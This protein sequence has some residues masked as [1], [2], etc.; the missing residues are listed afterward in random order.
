MGKM[1]LNVSF[2]VGFVDL[3]GGYFQVKSFFYPKYCLSTSSGALTVLFTCNSADPNQRFRVTTE[4]AVNALTSDQIVNTM[5]SQKQMAENGQTNGTDYQALKNILLASLSMVDVFD[6]SFVILPNGTTYKP[7][8]QEWANAV[9]GAG[10]LD[11]NLKVYTKSAKLIGTVDRVLGVTQLVIAVGEDQQ[12]FNAD[13]EAGRIPGNNTLAYIT[14][15]AAQTATT[16]LIVSQ[17]CIPSTFFGGTGPCVIG[18][19]TA[20]VSVGYVVEEQVLFT[21]ESVLTQPNVC[22]AIAL[23]KWG[24]NLLPPAEEQAL[25]AYIDLF[26]WLCN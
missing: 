20:G 23:I 4:I 25:N 15:W 6:D 13:I 24:G 14:A 1:T 3:G 7:T 26:G 2:Y 16:T 8:L 12:M 9:D 22:A 18:A 10:N 17:A 11:P 5:Q 19:V 21:F